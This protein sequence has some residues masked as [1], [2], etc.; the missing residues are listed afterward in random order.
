MIV[1]LWVVVAFLTL[2]MICFCLAGKAFVHYVQ[3]EDREMMFKQEEDRN[4]D[5]NYNKMEIKS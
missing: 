1:L 2:G 5:Q 4:T 3:E